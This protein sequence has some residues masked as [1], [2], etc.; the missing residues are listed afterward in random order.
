MH[1]VNG[2]CP[3][4]TRD[5]PITSTPA[6]PA[7]PPT[8]Q[9]NSSGTTQSGKKDPTI[10]PACGKSV[11]PGGYGTFKWGDDGR[12]MYHESC[13]NGRGQSVNS[14]KPAKKEPA[15]T[16]VP[17]STPGCPNGI[18]IGQ[19][20]QIPKTYTCSLCYQKEQRKAQQGK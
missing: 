13:W 16:F 2:P 8:S 4:E 17:C 11:A 10:C 14:A 18:R 1:H 5:V 15:D 6:T 7:A 12:T 19:G 3:W 20:F 9:G